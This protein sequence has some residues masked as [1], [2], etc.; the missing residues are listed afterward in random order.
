MCLLV[1]PSTLFPFFFKVFVAMK[2]SFFVLWAQPFLFMRL[3]FFQNFYRNNNL[4][5]LFV[6]GL[7]LCEGIRE[8]CTMFMHHLFQNRRSNWTSKEDCF[9]F[10]KIIL[11]LLYNYFWNY[12]FSMHLFSYINNVNILQ[13]IPLKKLIR[14]SLVMRYKICWR[15]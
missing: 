2:T 13:V 3:C 9:Y 8:S 14:F 5:F 11:F 6:L 4:F 12:W 15:K 10:I 7:T 1:W